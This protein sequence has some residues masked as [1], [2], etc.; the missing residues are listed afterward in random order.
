MFLN[1]SEIHILISL[2]QDKMQLMTPS[3]GVYNGLT[4][5]LSL[6]VAATTRHRKYTN[7]TCV[8][9]GVQFG[10]VDPTAAVSMC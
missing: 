5:R 7:L 1:I 2:R 8:H 10:E 4:V 9:K 6:S 3:V